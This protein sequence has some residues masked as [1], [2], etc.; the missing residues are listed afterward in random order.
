MAILAVDAGRS[1]VE[2]KWESG[3]KAFPSDVSYAK[4]LKN[5]AGAVDDLEIHM[6]GQKWWVGKIASKEGKRFKFNNFG[7]S[8]ADTILKVQVIASAIYA[9]LSEGEIEL[10]VL[11]PVKEFTKEERGKIRNI[12]RGTHKF[13]YLLGEKKGV[14]AEEKKGEIIINKVLIVQ[15]GV[16]AYWSNKQDE[17]TQTLDFGAKTINYC[18]HDDEQIIDNMSSGTIDGGWETM[19]DLNDLRGEN[20]S[21]IDDQKKEEMSRELAQKAI[22]EVRLKEWSSE[23]KT[24][25][26]GGVAKDVLPYVQQEFPRAVVYPNPRNGNVNGLY[27]IL[28]EE[29]INV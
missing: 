12:L 27:N 4:E 9:G 16:A 28:E 22:S 26:F 20:D 2:A 7:Q 23:Y 15:E 18:V 5:K 14:E 6:D 1:E 21:K 8:K 29:L 10:G 11:V 19:K 3:F 13:S 25:V 24:Q 17:H